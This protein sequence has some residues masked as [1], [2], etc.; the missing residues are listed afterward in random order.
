VRAHV[1]RLAAALVL[2]SAFVACGTE[3]WNRNQLGVSNPYGETDET[4]PAAAGGD[5][6]VDATLDGGTT[7]GDAAVDVRT[8]ARPADARSDARDATSG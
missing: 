7:T 6:S 8:D 4:E 5:D 1:K 2:V 3:E